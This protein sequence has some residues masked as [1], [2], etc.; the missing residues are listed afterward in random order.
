MDVYRSISQ[1]FHSYPVGLL[2]LCLALNSCVSYIRFDEEKSGIM[3]LRGITNWNYEPVLTLELDT[4][5]SLLIKEISMA[6]RV[7]ADTAGGIL[8][9]HNL[10]FRNFELG[11][12]TPH[13]GSARFSSDSVYMERYR[14]AFKGSYEKEYKATLDFAEHPF[15]KEL[16][17][18]VSISGLDKE[19]KPFLLKEN[20]ILKGENKTGF[21]LYD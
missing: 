13:A 5:D 1:Y 21:F 15:L 19:G 10:L 16:D 3:S 6:V 18:E 2:F 8:H 11:L 17:I 9:E 7:P 12:I 4:E 14:N 20:L